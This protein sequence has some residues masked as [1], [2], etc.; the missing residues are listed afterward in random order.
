MQ[1]LQQGQPLRNV[2]R[3][4]PPSPHSDSILTA[5]LLLVGP[6]LLSAPGHSPVCHVLTL[7]SALTHRQK[8][9]TL[10]SPL[11]A[12]FSAVS[13]ASGSS[14]Q[15]TCDHLC[16]F[17]TGVISLYDC[18]FKRRLDYNQKL[19]RDDREHAKNLGLHINEEVRHTND[20]N[21]PT[22]LCACV[23]ALMHKCVHTYNV[24][25]C[26]YAHTCVVGTHACIMCM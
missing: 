11:S 15:H 10:R 18:V 1:K 13:D 26:I 6:E 8:V 9:C 16:L 20:A 3:R 22:E 4:N 25:M 24:N 7:P 5:L 23:C 21:K 17:Q 2:S 14:F 12:G 19:H